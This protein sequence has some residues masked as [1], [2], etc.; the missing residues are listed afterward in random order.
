MAPM[1]AIQQR[2]CPSTCFITTKVAPLKI[3]VNFDKNLDRSGVNVPQVEV[4]I[5]DALSRF[6][7]RITRVEVHLRDES[8]GRTT[9]GDKR[10]MIE[11][12][13]AGEQPV[14]VVSNADSV[15]EAIGRATAK[16]QHLLASS[17]GKSNDQVAG[18]DTTRVGETGS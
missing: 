15:D 6:R 17:F 8:A 5:G 16:M 12:R 10:C 7:D 14:A 11:A 2:A 4:A 1:A 13:V 3:Q 18:G 9:T